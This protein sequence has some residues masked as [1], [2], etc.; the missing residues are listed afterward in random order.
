MSP[1][2]FYL[3]LFTLGLLGVGH[4]FEGQA[5]ISIADIKGLG[6]AGTRRAA[7]SESPRR[8]LNISS[9]SPSAKNAGYWSQRHLSSSWP[10]YQ[11][12]GVAVLVT[13]QVRVRSEEHLE[14]LRTA[15]AGCDVFVV[16]YEEYHSLAAR[17]A[18]P[19]PAD[20][21]L[22]LSKDELAA[23]AARALAAA[24]RA[25][26]S[27]MAHNDSA[28]PARTEFP[29]TAWQWFALARALQEW[30]TLL[31]APG[32]YHALAR[33]RTDARLPPDLRLGLHLRGASEIEPTGAGAGTD[34]G[35]GASAGGDVPDGRAARDGGGGGGEHSELRRAE[36]V[37]R[38]A[39]DGAAGII[40]A[41]SDVFFY[42]SPSLFARIFGPFY[43]ASVTVYLREPTASEAAASR[44]ALERFGGP[45]SC[46]KGA[47]F[48]PFEE[49]LKP[50]Q[51]NEEPATMRV[52]R[53]RLSLMHRYVAGGLRRGRRR[54]WGS[55]DRHGPRQ[56]Q[57]QGQGQGHGKLPATAP[58]PPRHVRTLA[59]GGKPVA[60]A[61]RRSGTAGARPSGDGGPRSGGR[62]KLRTDP[63]SKKYTVFCGCKFAS[64]WR[65]AKS[66]EAFQSEPAMAHAVLASNASCLPLDLPH[67]EAFGLLDGRGGFKWG[68]DAT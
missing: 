34:Q 58:P 17:L 5:P 63:R 26:G 46:L 57:R 50:L 14:A 61:G 13:G 27:L 66:G 23:E 65:R 68:R 62:R 9:F 39:V 24:P 22:I 42:A 15:T 56:G 64:A 49:R 51:A 31:L 4:C 40:F 59:A 1:R 41:A 45:P 18:R 43:S 33:L 12:G 38:G 28:R 25:S 36:S 55:K 11:S 19:S 54:L 52:T 67:R 29:S 53:E 60:E 44:E 10:P 16:T 8:A 7:A 3:R 48:A 21:V 47:L 32:R 20:R 30:R 6:K 2:L 35:E 37:G